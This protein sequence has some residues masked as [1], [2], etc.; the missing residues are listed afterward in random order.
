MRNARVHEA[1]SLGQWRVRGHR[2]HNFRELHQTI[3]A[4]PVPSSTMG[5]DTYLWKHVHG[6]YEDNFSALQTWEQIRCKKSE[7]VWS[8]SLWF[9]QGIPRCAFIVWL[10]VQNRLSTGDRMRTWRI[11]QACVLCGE[12]DET[13][14]HLFF[15]CPYSCTVWDRLACRLVGRRINQDWQDM[16]QFIQTGAANQLDQVIIRLVFQLVVCHVWTERNKHIHQQGQLGTEQMITQI[17]KKVKNKI[18]SLRY[19]F[20]HSLSG[21]MRRWFEVI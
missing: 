21:L 19:K 20:D 6:V 1:V 8:R 16:L 9:T 7:V 2:S 15:V 11:Q 12:R 17:N 3:Q 14:D 10:S 4:A 5:E 18:T 13:R